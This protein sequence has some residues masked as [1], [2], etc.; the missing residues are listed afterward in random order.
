MALTLVGAIALTQTACSKPPVEGTI[1]NM[2]YTPAYSYPTYP[3]T[4]WTQDPHT[5]IVT[6]TRKVGNSYVTS[7]STQTYYTSRC[8]AHTMHMNYM[9]ATWRMCVDGVDEDGKKAS[10]CFYTDPTNFARYSKGS[11]WVAGH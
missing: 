7:S 6:T 11:H 4:V 8:V 1:T 10:D 5:R 3:C 2:S 9:P